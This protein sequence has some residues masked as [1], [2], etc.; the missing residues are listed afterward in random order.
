MSD[1]WEVTQHVCG[2]CFG[3]L[4]VRDSTTDETTII[5]CADCGIE[6]EG[7]VKGLCS[8]GSRLNTGRDAGFRCE[9]N[10][11][12]LPGVTQQIVAVYRGGK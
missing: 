11:D 9:K 8:C 3:R 2:V 5:R 6:M 4:L 12:H 7:D 1:K 10:P